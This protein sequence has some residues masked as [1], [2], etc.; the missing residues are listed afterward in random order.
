MLPPPLFRIAIMLL[1]AVSAAL[2]TAF[3]GGH[4][5]SAL[6]TA[7]QPPT[8]W[9]FY[10][11]AY[12]VNNDLNDKNS[13]YTLGCNQGTYDASHSPP[14]NSLVVLDFGVQNSS[15]SATIATF[16]GATFTNAQIETMAE[17]FSKEY[18]ICT[19]T[20]HTSVLTLG[21]GTNNSVKYSDSTYTTLGSDWANVVSAVIAYN[22]GSG[23]HSQV[24]VWG[25]N[26]LEDWINPGDNFI[27][28]SDQ[29]TAWVNGY[30]SLDPAPYVNYGSAN[31]CPTSGYANLNCDVFDG[32]TY[33]QYDYW[34][35]SWG[36]NPALVTPEIYSSSMAQQWTQISLYDKHYKLNNMRFQAPWD[37]NDINTSTLTSGQAWSDLWNDLNNAGV[38]AT[39][40]DSAQIHCQ[41]GVVNG[42]CQT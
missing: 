18:Y 29:T 16:S 3:A 36:A 40:Y 5:P 2:A 35:Y 42:R 10:V 20:D 26:D 30:S 38:I 21:L 9:S 14:V 28:P 27:I 23:V 11:T 22:N 31:G 7:T 12:D 4:I 33:N 13:L 41:Y 24:T 1:V 6:A 25:A 34:W 32:T 37:E 8:D 15:G 39:M 17:T 19:G